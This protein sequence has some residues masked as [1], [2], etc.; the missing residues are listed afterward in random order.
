MADDSSLEL[1]LAEIR[2]IARRPDRLSEAEDLLC[3]LIGVM[4]PAELLASQDIIQVTIQQLFLPKRRTRL[5][6]VLR[7][8]AG[9]PGSTA[10][11]QTSPEEALREFRVT[12]SAA[13]NEISD[14]HIFNWAHYEDTLSAVFDQAIPRALGL[15]VNTQE[16]AV[17]IRELVAFHASEVFQKGYQHSTTK[18]DLTS[19]EAVRRSL[20][21][22]GRLLRVSASEYERQ[23]SRL[24]RSGQV[25]SLRQHSS[26]FMAGFLSGSVQARMG[27]GD[28]P[29]RTLEAWRTW[30]E[31]APYLTVNDL[32]HIL[33]EFP[34]SADR[35]NIARIA[36]PLSGALDEH[37]RLASDGQVFTLA[38]SKYEVAYDRLEVVIGDP[39]GR[40]QRD[41]T[42]HCYLTE[43]PQVQLQ[44][45]SEISRGMKLIALPMSED[46]A[47]WANRHTPPLVHYLIDTTRADNHDRLRDLLSVALAEIG[48]ALPLNVPLTYNFA[49][50][51]PLDQPEIGPAF[52]V[53]RESVLGLLEAHHSVNG[54]RVWCSVRRSGKTTAC[55]DL[56]AFKGQSVVI[57]E[58]CERTGIAGLS[59]SFYRACGGA[60][61]SAEPLPTTFVA[62]ALR[63]AAPYEIGDSRIIFV[64]DE[65]ESL[66]AI[67]ESAAHRDAE[68]RYRVVQPLLNQ[69]V[70][71]AQRNLIIFLGLRP[72]AHFILMDQNQLSPYV[73]ADQFPLF[74]FERDDQQ[75]EFRELVRRVL[76]DRIPCDDGFLGHLFAETGGHPVMTVNVLAALCDWLIE[77][78]RPVS[79]LHLDAR[80]FDKFAGTCLTNDAI[81]L[82]AEYEI[83]R[84]FAQEALSQRSR[85]NTPWLYGVLNV[86]RALGRNGS[87]ALS[88]AEVEALLQRLGLADECGLN[89]HDLIRTGTMANFFRRTGMVIR[90]Q[91]RLYAR[92]AATVSGSVAGR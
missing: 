33:N 25:A 58:T 71:F 21:G 27:S 9:A 11:R 55:N 51:F 46:L 78:A 35:T 77:G 67:L 2:E 50:H 5:L 56:Q 65:Y 23:L 59:D 8:V 85:A 16:L 72:D 47:R 62:D 57:T 30:V 37:V 92:L 4:A 49:R 66:F 74:P 75:C 18:Q 39:L 73:V 79:E 69:L 13:L 22:L 12:L 82:S 14:R 3:E 19:E 45:E 68:L 15:G 52:R 34:Q 53:R 7:D 88:I 54:I 76:S 63:R 6:S 90:P 91:I 70:A 32:V 28:G 86:M 40:G 36:R 48:S 29:T 60:L 24:R 17:P 84:R 20:A 87:G 81:A 64:L 43:S 44:V 31:F 89:A 42:I 80:D 10:T 61:S 1:R 38:R 26:A 41:L 83:H